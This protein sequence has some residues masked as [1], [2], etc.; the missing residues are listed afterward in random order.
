[1]WNCSILLEMYFFIIA[2][3][4]YKRAGWNGKAFEL[5][6]T[7]IEYCAFNLQWFCKQLNIQFLEIII[8]IIII[9]I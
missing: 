2:P 3:T 9:I 4:D 8:F 6:V 5:A 7:V 1:M